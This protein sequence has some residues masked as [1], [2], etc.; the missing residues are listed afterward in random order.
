M[1]SFI[2]F[3][4]SDKS[5]ELATDIVFFLVENSPLRVERAETDWIT[6]IW[7]AN[8]VEMIPEEP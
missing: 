5:F 4:I 3:Y 2:L 8:N 7:I 6:T 1:H